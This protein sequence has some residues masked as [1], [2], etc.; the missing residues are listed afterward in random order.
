MTQPFAVVSIAIVSIVFGGTSYG[1][2][3][4]VRGVPTWVR[5]THGSNVSTA[6]WPMVELRMGPQSV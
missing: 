2:T 4:R 3:K 6:L 1:A 5:G